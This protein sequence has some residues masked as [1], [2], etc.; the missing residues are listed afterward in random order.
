MSQLGFTFYPKDWWASDSFYALN[1]F[2][3]YIYLELIF[4]MYVNGGFVSNNK[5]NA[6]RRLHTSIKED[7][8]SKITDLMVK[9][10]DQLTH[11]SVNSRLRKTL[12]NRQNGKL[13]G[14]PKKDGKNPNNPTLKPNENPHYKENRIEREI[15]DEDNNSSAA[16]ISATY[17][18]ATLRDIEVLKKECLADQVNFIEHV[19]RQNKIS[20]GIIPQ[21]LSDFNSHLRSVDVFLKSKTDYRQHFQYWFKKQDRSTGKMI[22]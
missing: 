3:R 5:V 19:C 16:I 21:A 11:R 9:D 12:S 22:L 17:G 14:R 1:P 15:E 2:E 18:A 4:M 8:W 7:V 13:G 6:E 20:P 10:G